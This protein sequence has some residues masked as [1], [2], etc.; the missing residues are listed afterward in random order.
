MQIHEITQLRQVDEGL[1]SFVSG[2]S[3]GITDKLTEPSQAQ[4][5]KQAASA[6]SKLTAQG[7]GTNYKQASDKW[8]DKFAALQ[9][10]TAVNSYAKGLAA[11]WAKTASGLVQP[12]Q[13]LSNTNTLQKMVPSLVSA[14][15]KSNNTLTT[16]QIGQI[17]AKSAPTIWNNT[18]DKSSAIGQLS[19]E[20]AQQGIKVGGAPTVTASAKTIPTKPTTVIPYGKAEAPGVPVVKGAAKAGA[21]TPEEQAKLQAKIAAATS[22]NP[23]TMNEAALIG[24]AAEQY[25]QAFLQWSDKQMASRV[26]E[27]GDTVTMNDVRSKFPDLDT[28]LSQA[29]DQVVQTQNTPNQTQAIEN[30]IKLAVAGVQ[31]VSQSFKNKVS[32]TSAVQGAATAAKLGDVK[33]TL[34][35]AGIDPTRLAQFGAAAKEAGSPMMAK[36]SNDPYQN[37]LLKLAGWTVR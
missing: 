36:A 21:P 1:G 17:L 27:T 3:G 24:P 11:G 34:R 13:G 7:Y 32:A 4:I 16:T 6:A 25:K 26:P 29:L 9:K 18:A 14:A 30:Y 22:G 15:K 23:P 5:N 37:A 20:L 12:A 33:Q 31:A 35:S 28:K 8:E 10:D 19:A 2:L